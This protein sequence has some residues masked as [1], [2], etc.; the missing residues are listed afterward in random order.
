MKKQTQTRLVSAF[1]LVELIVVIT[2]LAIL[3]TIA[4]TSL[5]WYS[6]NARDSIRISDL[7]NLEKWFELIRTKDLKL[8]IPQNKVDITASSTIVSYQWYAWLDV[9]WYIWIA[10]DIK[11]PKDKINYTYISDVNLTKYQILWFLENPRQTSYIEDINSNNSINSTNIINK[12]NASIDY[13]NRFPIVK[14]KELWIFTSID[15]TPIQETWTWIDI[16]NTNDTY[17]VILNNTNSGSVSGTWSFLAKTNST[18]N[19]KRIYDLWERKDWIYTINPAWVNISV[20]CDM[21]TDWGGW[22]LLVTSKSKWWW[23]Y[24]QVMENN[25]SSPS[26]NSNYSILWKW[27][28]IKTIN[29]WKFIY[30]IDASNFWQYWWIWEVPE[31]YSFISTSNLNTNISLLKKYWTWSYGDSNIEQ[32]MPYMCNTT[33]WLLSTSLSCSSNRRGTIL[34]YNTTFLPAPWA[35]NQPWVIWYWVK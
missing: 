5:Q 27:D 28:I 1:T 25:I 2:I 20:Y 16:V 30:R 34:V 10:T 4:F 7:K 29:N 6:I 32:R 35:W 13:T 19:C 11:D 22:T 26:I 33:S 21:T 14:W 12:V 23:L 24:S 9:Y 15:N 18:A 8:P 17:K 3:W 31:S